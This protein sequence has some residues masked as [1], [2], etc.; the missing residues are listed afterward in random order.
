MNPIYTAE[1]KLLLKNE[2]Q[3]GAHFPSLPQQ[4]FIK[5]DSV[6]IAVIKPNIGK[7]IQSTKCPGGEGE[8]PYKNDGLLVR[9]LIYPKRYQTLD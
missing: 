3:Q 4:I 7:P 1:I 2:Y 9:N 8:L 6:L 5:K